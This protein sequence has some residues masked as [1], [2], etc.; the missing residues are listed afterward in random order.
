M[1]FRCFY[2]FSGFVMKERL[3]KNLEKI[4]KR[5]NSHRNEIPVIEGM[6]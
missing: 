2:R 3:F 5:R 1:A 4:A 6:V